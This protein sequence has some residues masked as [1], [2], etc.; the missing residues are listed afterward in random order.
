PVAFDLIEAI[1]DNKQILCKN[2][3]C[4]YEFDTNL[5]EKLEKLL[6]LIIA[7]RE[8]ESILGDVNV[9]VST[10]GGTVKIPYPLL[11]TRLNTLI[12]LEMNGKKVEFHLRIEPSSPETFK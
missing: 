11:L 6:K 8:A 1:E 5:K 12:T 9:C 10:P 7:V 4:P 3:H 2:C